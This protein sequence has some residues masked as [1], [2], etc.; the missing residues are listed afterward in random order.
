MKK[1][2]AA[3]CLIML[4]IPLNIFGAWGM[5]DSDRS[6]ITINKDGSSSS[7]TLWNSGTGTFD[8]ANLGS[9][10]SGD[11]LQITAFDVK[12]WKNSGGDVTGIEYFYKVYKQGGSEPSF[13]SMGGGF[14]ADLG[15]DNQKWGVTSATIDLLDGVNSAGTWVVE[16]YGSVSGTTPAE[17]ISDNNTGSN[18]L[19]TFSTDASLPVE[20]STFSIYSSAKGVKLVWTTDS[21]IENQGF[22][23]LR[24]SADKDWAEL[25]SFTKH[26]ALEGQGSTT[27][28]TDYYFIDTQV[29]EGL[30][31]SYQL[32][33]VDYQGKKIYHKDHIETITY[34]NPGMNTKPNALKVVKLY[35][36][37]F[38]PTVTLTYDLAEK[39]DLDVSVYNLAGEQVWHYARGGHPAGQNYTLTW[40]GNDMQNTPVPSG[41]YLVN[42]QAGAQ[43]KSEKV[44]LLRQIY[45]QSC[46]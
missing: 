15:S 21:E 28:A 27:E 25:A 23:I 13:V 33:D 5:F 32:I 6:W 30:S 3:S 38:N 42:I 24:K 22:V 43:I 40:N 1:Y 34:V 8:G 45:S 10:A 39:N 7:Y 14:L 16:V 37:P 26:P 11:V 35:P 41:I 4:L 29:K 46:Y 19:A 2:V 9:Y 44:T 20:L 12:T 36:N 18:Y 31:Y 17:T